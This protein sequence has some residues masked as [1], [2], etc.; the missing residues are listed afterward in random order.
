VPFATWEV[1][2]VKVVVVTVLFVLE[3]ALLKK[4]VP[5]RLECP[6]APATVMRLLLASLHAEI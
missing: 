1:V 3:L 5:F 6:S 4:Y 2:I